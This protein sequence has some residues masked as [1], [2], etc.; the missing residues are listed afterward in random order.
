MKKKFSLVLLMLAVVCLFSSCSESGLFKDVY[1][2]E[3]MNNN[4]SVLADENGD[5]GDWIEL[6]NP[7]ASPINLSGYMLSDN[8]YN[9]DQF[10]FPEFTIGAGEYFVVFAD[11]TE[12]IDTENRII[13]VPFSLSSKGESICLYNAKGRLLCNFVTNKPGK[14][15]STGIDEKGQFAFFDTPTPGKANNEVLADVPVANVKE[16]TG[17]YI[18]EYSTNSTA[19]LTDDEG[20]FVSWVEIYNSSD[21]DISLK[22]CTLS[23]DFANKEKWAFPAIKV[24]AGEYL[25]VYLSGKIREYN[26]EKSFVHADFSLKGDEEFLY[27]FDKNQKEIDSCRVFDL[28]SN[29]TCGRKKDD[30][31]SFAFFAKATPGKANTQKAFESVDS[32]RYT[33]NKSISITEVAAVNTTVPQSSQG[34]YFDYVELHNNTDEDI[35]LKDYKLSESKKAESFKSLPDRVL[36]AG[37]YI[38]IYCDDVDRVSNV[39]GNIY[40]SMGLNRYCETVYLIDK[41]GIVVDSL[42]YGRVSSGYF[43]GRE[44]D[45][46]DET[47]YYSSLTPG[48]ENPKTTLKQALSNPEFSQ[49]STYLKKGSE[50]TL[51]CSDGEIR[52]TTDGSVPTKKSK[53]FSEAIKVN[54]TTAFRARAFKEG[55]VPSD[56]I[57]ATYIVGKKHTLPVV[58][59]TTDSKNLYD[60]NTGIWA[61]GPGKGS[62]FPYVGAN[63]WKDWERPVNFEF[64]T[65]DGVA[66]VQFDAG[67]KVFGQ[68]SRALAQKSV[69]INL[70]DKYGLKEV[71]YPFFED[72]DVNVFSSL[73]LRNS[74]Q[75]FSK[76]HIRDAY[77]AMVIKNSID[78]D[79][80]DYQ[81][82]ITYVNGK[83]HGI[84][85]LREKLDEDYLANH[86]GVDSENVDFIKG[87]AIVQRGSMDNY[88]A[89]LEYIKTHDMRKDEH[90][91]YVCS[92]IDID[93]LISY[94]MCES[95]FTN[96]DTGNIRF[97][98]E[99]SEGSKW[100]WIFF[101]VDWALFPSTYTYNY[102]NNYL[103]PEGHGVGKMF[104]T[105]I[106]SNLIKNKSFRT[107]LLEIHSKHLK[108][109]F[110]TERLLK[111]FD[112]LVEEIRPEMKEHCERWGAISYN[113]WENSIVA[114]RKIISEKREI[115]IDDM[116]ESFNMTAEEIEKY[117]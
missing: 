10:V 28:T 76:S 77:C 22:G 61:D 44:V 109:T 64:M 115:F 63:Y 11:G 67:I 47:V 104:N 26:S 38:A 56:T 110:E 93:E 40:V 74:G 54:Q 31:S 42:N 75:D 84:Y 80:M 53:L 86:R 89:L 82:V 36:K 32:A 112:E 29:L 85:D 83:Y 108:T 15:K 34:E 90:Y 72:N 20:E 117:L 101:D 25:V 30:V 71:C 39:T 7:T 23:D 14:D 17:L 21:K 96:T 65:Q 27:I 107:R 62:E 114:L 12:K 9:V 94:W 92:Q 79:I 69:S 50:I 91:K 48:K 41:K 60:Y 52:Y 55:Y 16:T 73:I 81:P 43:A 97:Y 18:N 98:R 6:H 58:F 111:I 105:T 116:K 24:K 2:S 13:H 57:S 46:V 51:S 49:G 45:S 37:D 1:I 113:A 3:V 95:F 88:K 5:F 33:G 99:N 8:S 103:N 68:Y 106:M 100:R 87:N 4:K 78:V 66:Q 35:N 19:T 102:I 59:L 70:R